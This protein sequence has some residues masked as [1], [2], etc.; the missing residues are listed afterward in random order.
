VGGTFRGDPSD[1]AGMSGWQ[2]LGELRA[3]TPGP[4][5]LHL[6]FA[7]GIGRLLNWQCAC[8]EA[9][10]MRGHTAF[11]FL[12]SVGLRL[13]PETWNG[14]SLGAE[15]IMPHWLGLEDARQPGTFTNPSGA[16]DRVGLARS[17]RISLALSQWTALAMSR[18][19]KLIVADPL[20][21]ERE[22][23]AALAAA[24]A[25]SVN[26]TDRRT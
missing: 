23:Y 6:R 2:L 10:V 11:S 15:V 19:D 1:V 7:A 5:Q 24:L 26:R 12:A 20:I 16:G 13:R 14:F 18:Q 3:H 9:N 17:D 21:A 4:I 8:T 25:S 22:R